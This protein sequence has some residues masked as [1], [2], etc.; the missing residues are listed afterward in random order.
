MIKDVG[1]TYVPLVFKIIAFSTFTFGIIVRLFM[2]QLASNTKLSIS[3]L[4]F[5]PKPPINL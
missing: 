1:H 3:I 4:G 2:R 5:E